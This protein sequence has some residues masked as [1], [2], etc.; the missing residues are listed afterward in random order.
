MAHT[1]RFFK[2]FI[3]ETLWAIPV[4]IAVRDCVATVVRVDGASSE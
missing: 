1:F 2:S 3:T 4:A